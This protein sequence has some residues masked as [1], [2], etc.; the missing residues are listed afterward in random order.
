LQK[1]QLVKTSYIAIFD[2]LKQNLILFSSSGNTP[3]KS[4][5]DKKNLIMNVREKTESVAWSIQMPT[6]ASPSNQ[7]RKTF[8]TK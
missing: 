6:N 4:Q 2:L 1:T 3:K 5:E 7:R 8:K